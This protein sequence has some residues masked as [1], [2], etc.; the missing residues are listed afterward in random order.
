M[1]YCPVANE[2][3][4]AAV[5]QSRAREQP[6]PHLDAPKIIGGASIGFEQLAGH[7]GWII[8]RGAL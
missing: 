3:S 4:R 1:Q 2:I 6:R 8:R 5:C 7:V